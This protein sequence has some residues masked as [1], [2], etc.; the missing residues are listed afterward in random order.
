MAS[1]AGLAEAASAEDSG[2]PPHGDPTADAASND[3]SDA[4]FDD[5]AWAGDDR[6]DSGEE[7]DPSAQ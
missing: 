3:A 5:P 7:P 2:T 6:D 1:E 4:G